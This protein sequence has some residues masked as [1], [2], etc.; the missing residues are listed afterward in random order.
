M[1]HLHRFIGSR[2]IAVAVDFLVLSPGL[3]SNT[4]S[5]DDIPEN[6]IKAVRQAQHEITLGKG[7]KK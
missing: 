2:V 4:L 5:G 7:M 6:L 3:L 1:R